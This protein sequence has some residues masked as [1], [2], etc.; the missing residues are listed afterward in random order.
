MKNRR[1]EGEIKIDLVE[2][3]LMA[4]VVAMAAG[5]IMPE[6]VAQASQMAGQFSRY[7]V[8]AASIGSGA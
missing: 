5:A 1:V 4:G 3:G 7:L 8:V 2:Y 6:L